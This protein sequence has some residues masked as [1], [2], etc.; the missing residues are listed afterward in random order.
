[1]LTSDQYKLYKL[2]SKNDNL[3]KVAVSKSKTKSLDIYDKGS[4]LIKNEIS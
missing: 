1:M 4:V 3:G 2:V